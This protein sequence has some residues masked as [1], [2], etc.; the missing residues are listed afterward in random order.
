[1]DATHLD[2]ARRL[3]AR[4][5]PVFQVRRRA[6]RGGL[7]GSEFAWAVAFVIPYVALFLVF[8]AYPVVYGLWL[9]H[10]PRLYPELFEGPIYQRPGVNT[11]LYLS[12]GATLHVFH[13][14][15]P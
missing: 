12:I 8:V 14:V 2:A 15:L 7:Q 13:A 10:S 3:P 9:G 1:M 6:W 11:P 4:A 5:V